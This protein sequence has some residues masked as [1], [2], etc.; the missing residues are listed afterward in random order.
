M[1]IFALINDTHKPKGHVQPST[2]SVWSILDKTSTFNQSFSAALICD[3]VFNHTQW[4]SMV[5]VS[6]LTW[7]FVHHLSY[8]IKWS[9]SLSGV[10]C[11]QQHSAFILIEPVVSGVWLSGIFK[12]WSKVRWSIHPCF[13]TIRSDSSFEFNFKFCSLITVPPSGQLL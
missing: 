5:S 9:S 10:K 11:I 12:L 1:L 13:I 2:S 7:V 8:V 6:G 4:S 3:D